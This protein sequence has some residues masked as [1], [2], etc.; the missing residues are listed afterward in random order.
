MYSLFL[1][2]PNIFSVV[3]SAKY[4]ALAKAIKASNL[5]D[6]IHT[7][8][9]KNLLKFFRDTSKYN[10]GF[11]SATWEREPTYVPSLN[12]KGDA[13]EL[14]EINWEGNELTRRD[15]YNVIFDHTVDPS[16]LA[17]K[18]EFFGYHEAITQVALYKLLEDL[19][20]MD[21]NVGKVYNDT[22]EMWRS[23]NSATDSNIKY[24]E[25]DMAEVVPEYILTTEI[26][27][28]CN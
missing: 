21:E 20:V 14:T 6:S 19:K 16:D 27:K 3:S 15:P 10:L 1:S 11:V 13:V 4:K 7:K 2:D 25:L 9:I 5:Q 26:K 28:R 17:K 18:G 23:S 8:W 22:A 24:K 12:E